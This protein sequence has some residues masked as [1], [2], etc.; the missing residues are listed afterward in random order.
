MS[1]LL[2]SI[3]SNAQSLKAHSAAISVTGNNLAN[4]D[5]DNYSRQRVTLGSIGSTNT[6]E[7][8]QSMGITV[9]GVQSLRDAI[10]DSQIVRETSTQG[11][12]E[13][14]KNI[15]SWI[16]S[17]LGEAIS[18][19]E[20]E[21]A[22]TGISTALDDFF[23][24]WQAYSADPTENAQK[25][26]V[27][28]ATQVLT[29][30]LNNTSSSLSG[31]NADVLTEIGSQTDKVNNLLGD[32]ATLNDQIA[33]VTV[34]DPDG[35]SD[36]MDTR[37]GK[38]E[39]LAKY[40]NFTTQADPD[41]LNQIQVALSDSVGGSAIV[42]DGT[43]TQSVSYSSGEYYAGSTLLDVTGGSLEGLEAARSGILADTQ[44]ALDNIAAELVDAVNT[45]YGSNFFSAAGTSASTI[46][47]DSS[48]SISSLTAGSTGE[49][50]AND[51]ALA[52]AQLSNNSFNSAT[53]YIGGTFSDYYNQLVTDV[54]SEV[55]S[56]NQQMESS[57]LVSD[58]LYGQRQSISGV[59]L[60]E[61]M[62]N[63]I[64]YQRAYQ[65]SARVMNIMDSMLEI[66]VNGLGVG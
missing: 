15:A 21:G 26:A 3:Y 34:R 65:G 23:G 50:A 30:M 38:L 27:I 17:T 4:V 48:I 29:D 51:V 41:G 62:T 43:K 56:A 36:L 10:I 22:D 46:S 28:Q 7:G 59:S 2:S 24:A 18:T 42:V 54:G 64:A 40:I 60:D 5:N 12:L 35:A 45:A 11:S 25:Q 39:E 32:I 1:G 8:T 9:L 63:L 44:T 58:L 20:S 66:V 47:L 37:Q 14:Q 31:M 33:R 6:P 52:I 13:A 55:A 16:E 57:K 61:E 49:A 53:D 19:L